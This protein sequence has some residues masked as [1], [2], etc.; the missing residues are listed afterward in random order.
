MWQAW[1]IGIAVIEIYSFCVMLL[2]KSVGLKKYG[3]CMIPF[4][5]FYYVQRVAQR[6]TIFSIP[7]KKY[8]GV[9]L[10]L[11]VT[12]LVCTLLVLWAK[13]TLGVA[14]ENYQCFIEI[15]Y[16]PIAICAIVAWFGIVQSTCAIMDRF[17]C[18]FRFDTLLYCTVLPCLVAYV[19]VAVKKIEFKY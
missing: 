1:I 6:F 19:I 3:L 8:M 4:V 7:V 9:M 14:T 13:P 12:L 5:A 16:I 15:L 2:A 17:G 18:R 11:F 10:S